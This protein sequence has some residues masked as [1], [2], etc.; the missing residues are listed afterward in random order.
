MIVDQAARSS[1]L[2]PR[3]SYIVQAPAGAGK[4]ELLT[5][6]FL[7]LLA[8]VDENPEEILAV[9][10]TKKAA[11]E[12]R[13]RIVNALIQ[14]KT[15]DSP[16]EKPHEQL[17]WQ[18]A[19]AALAKNDANHWQLIENPNRLRVVTIDAFCASLVNKMPILS[20]FGGDFMVVEYAQS[21]YEEAA[22][23]LV[24]QTTVDDKWVKALE[25]LLL[26]LDNRMNNIIALLVTLLAQRDQWL[27]YLRYLSTGAE[28]LQAYF[29]QSLQKLIANHLLKL[30]KHFSAS[31]AAT[32]MQIAAQAANICIALNKSNTIVRLAELTQLPAA[33]ADALALWQSLADLLL[34]KDGDFRKRFDQNVGFLSQSAAK[35]KTEKAARKAQQEQMQS[36][37]A[38]F[39][40]IEGLQ[41]LLHECRLLPD[42]VLSTQQLAILTALGDILPVLVAHL[43]IIFQSHGQVDFIEVNLRASEALGDALAP[44]DILLKLD[45][46]LR[47][48]L[49]DEYQ[50]T[51]VAQYRLF[52]KLVAGWQNN[53][54][55]TLFLVGD[56]M[57]S[58]YRFRG[59]EV[60][61][62]LHTQEKG[63][64]QVNLT[65]LTLQVNFRSNENVIKWVN[66]TFAN[67]FPTT[68]NKTF[69]AVTYSQAIAAKNTETRQDVQL[70]PIA[71]ESENLAEVAVEL[72]I[73]T[74]T[75]HPNE[76]IAVL[77]RTKRDLAQI[78]PL[79]KKMSIGFVAHEVDHLALRPHVMDLVSLLRATTDW[80][81]K[82]SW[83]AILRAPWL[84]LSLNDIFII[85][86]HNSSGI[87]WDAIQQYATYDDL[88]L[89][90]RAR[91]DI[92]VPVM[93]QWLMHRWRKPLHE[94]LRGLWIFLGGVN[95]YQDSVMMDIDAVF[96]L[97]CQTEESGI[98]VDIEGFE[99]RLTQLYADVANTIASQP[100]DSE[101][102]CV[103]LLTLH[104]AKGLE[105]DTVLMPYLHKRPKQ[106]DPA[107]LRWF[108]YTLDDRVDLLLAP[109][110]FVTEEFD[111]LY[112][113]VDHCLA[114]KDRY[115]LARLLYVGATRAKQRLYLLGEYTLTE[116]GECKAPAKGS[117]WEMLCQVHDLE[118]IKRD[119]SR[120]QQMTTMAPLE[121]AMPIFR[122]K[123]PYLLPN[124]YKNDLTILEETLDLNHPQV[125]DYVAR[126]AGTA[127]HRLLQRLTSESHSALQD[128]DLSASCE[129]PLQRMG[130]SGKELNAAMLLIKQAIAHFLTDDTGRWLLCQ[131]HVERRSEW[132][133]SVKTPF[134][135]DNIVIDYSFVD[136]AGIRWIIDYKLTHHQALTESVL[137]EEVAK[138]RPQLAKYRQ[139]LSRLEQRP[140][141]CGLYFPLAKVFSEIEF[142]VTN[143]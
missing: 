84:G 131:T 119:E 100:G 17:T 128:V 110:R 36:L 107:L 104:K 78:I 112:R 39:G 8:T 19:R 59:A 57:Q 108:E 79:L 90:A 56:P 14:A 85:A 24:T 88:S 72:I 63:L 30:Q 3:H 55:R 23:A 83:F 75:Q 60:S 142:G 116:E 129:L 12:M 99:A 41:T 113:Y 81:D 26:H 29:E 95:C 69:G 58:I 46:Q 124:E 91:L 118:A 130:L 48:I 106:N 2:N 9:T 34:T 70:I 11:G 20:Q 141:R 67:I 38:E 10:F 87:L 102:I 82:I 73:A 27:P 64:G 117:F 103:E 1:A 21:L 127:L 18:L 43:Q 121:T 126:C 15:V 6:R 111:P 139:I 94:W 47:H 76:T 122:L 134:G 132:A 137:A 65:P 35:D 61:L 51:S 138:Y 125:S 115:E 143:D 89:N 93:Q 62:F 92:F 4:T 53:D 101:N 42:A 7:A 74:L 31:A 140:I 40:A 114:Q 28:H 45:Y 44:S 16:P 52:E 32:L 71:K 50:D 136:K 109:Y 96:D 86:T 77:G 49:I 54:G 68:S 37:L 22:K 25:T 98:I 13:H 105:Y 66:Q 123:T 5:Q 97:I 133:L 135:V 80:T 33:S 120:H